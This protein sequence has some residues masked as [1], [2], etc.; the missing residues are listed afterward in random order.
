M[1]TTTNGDRIRPRTRFRF[2]GDGMRG[3]GDAWQR[4]FEC[5]AGRGRHHEARMNNVPAVRRTFQDL[6]EGLG[7][8][9]VVRPGETI[10][11]HCVVSKGRLKNLASGPTQ[12]GTS[13][14]KSR[15]SGDVE[16]QKLSVIG[17]TKTGRRG[18]LK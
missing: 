2:A 16:S 15:A 14:T 6:R 13:T 11:A 4:P 7:V 8:V 18:T 12:A 3:C 17:E 9:V 10:T 5:A 1:I